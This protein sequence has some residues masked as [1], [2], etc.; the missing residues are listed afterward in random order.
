[1]TM[2]QHTRE[3]NSMKIHDIPQKR[4]VVAEVCGETSSQNDKKDGVENRPQM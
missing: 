2:H 3:G 4:I 1:M